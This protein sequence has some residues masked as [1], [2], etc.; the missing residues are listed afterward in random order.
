MKFIDTHAHL[1]LASP[2]FRSGAEIQSSAEHD[3][4][5]VLARARAA[6]VTKIISMSSNLRAARNA[7][8]IAQRHDG[9]FATCGVHPDDT[10]NFDEKTLAELE[11][12]AQKE[13]VVAIGEIGFDF[14][15]HGEKASVEHQEA[16]FRAQL[17]LARVQKLPAVIHTREADEPT[18]RVLRDFEDLPL[19][20]HCYQSGAEM[21]AAILGNPLWKMSFTGLITFGDQKVPQVVAA[22]EVAPLEK[23]MIETD[24]PFL[25]PAPHRGEVNEPAFV[26]LVARKIAELKNLPLAEVAATTTATAEKFFGI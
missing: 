19:V 23:I 25:A 20:V 14:G 13:E 16:C 2:K 11:K 26:P 21:T 3:L 17:E 7:L 10:V 6:G 22:A 24:T 4:T 15:P 5:P 9:V 18:L 8:Q 1:D 12:L